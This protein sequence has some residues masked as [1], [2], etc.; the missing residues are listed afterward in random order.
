MGDFA[1][2]R[3]LHSD[4]MVV[5]M[6]VMLICL[7]SMKSY[8]PFE[9]PFLLPLNADSTKR[10]QSGVLRIKDVEWGGGP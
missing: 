8:A 6:R 7:L 4:G 3:I 1:L 10:G 5:T 2:S 9:L